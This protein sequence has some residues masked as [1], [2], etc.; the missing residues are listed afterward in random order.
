VNHLTSIIVPVY[1][2]R[3]T[4]SQILEKLLSLPFEKQIIVVDDGSQDGTATELGRF[5]SKGVEVIFLQ[6]NH[7]KGYAIRQA[8]PLAKGTATIIQDADLEYDPEVIPLLTKPIHEDKADVVYG[9]RFLHMRRFTYHAI[10]NLMI[11]TW[12]NLI[13]GMRLNDMETGAK[14]FR[15]ALLKSIPLKSDRFGFEPEI[16][17]RLRRMKIQILEIEYPHYI[18]RTHAEGK[19]IKFKDGLAAVWH[20]LKFNWF[21]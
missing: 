10:T 1:N 7:G 3:S 2:E 5:S 17:A 4:I 15:T 19:K 11:T 12:F 9:A 18:S 16:T 20:S 13:S 6:E 8:I 14:A 21:D